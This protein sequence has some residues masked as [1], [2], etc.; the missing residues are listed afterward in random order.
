MEGDGVGTMASILV[1]D[2]NPETLALLV[3]L[4]GSEDYRVLPADSGQLGLS[5]AISQSPD[6]IL[7]DMRMPGMDGLET[8]RRLKAEPLTRQIPVILMS[9]YAEV[10][11]WSAGLRAGAVD[12]VNK[13]FHAEELLA[14]IRTQLELGAASLK[15]EQTVATRTQ[16]LR[17]ANLRLDALWSLVSL[18][19]QEGAEELEDKAIY[20]FVLE[21]IVAMT[22]SRYGFFGLVDESETVMTIHAWSGQAMADCAMVHKPVEYR[23]AEVGL[24][25]EAVR[26][27]K[28]LV[29]NDYSAP[30]I[31]RKGYPG[32]HVQLTRLMV[33]PAFT[34]GRISA[35]AAVANKQGEYDDADLKQLMAFMDGVAMTLAHRKIWAELKASELKFHTV[36]DFTYDLE[37]WRAP[38]GKYVYVSPSCERIT[39][40]SAAEFMAGTGL[41]LEIVLPQDRVI[42]EKHYALEGPADQGEDRHID[43]R[44]I[45]KDGRVR[46]MSHYCTQ[47]VDG[48]GN[49]IGRRASNRDITDRKQTEETIQALLRDKDLLLHEVHHRIKNNMNSVASLLSLQRCKLQDQ[50]AI[51]ALETAQNR[52]RSMGLL[53]DRLYRSNHLQAMAVGNYLGPLVKEIVEAIPCHASI[54]IV[55]D[56]GDFELPAQVLQPLGIVVNEIVTN[57]LKYAFEGRDTGVIQVEACKAGNRVCITLGDDGVGLPSSINFE[58]SSGLGL[59]L[60]KALVE[61]MDA[62][63]R[64]E[65][66]EGTKFIVD[67]EG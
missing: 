14:R 60:I 51:D 48:A 33:V 7:L 19:N 45:T 16:E 53:Y 10:A 25:G 5:A 44:F 38:D 55:D 18:V 59:V 63:V 1:I 66:T 61:Q 2:D 57:S 26:Y 50:G 67:F 11:Q 13:P 40:Y 9:A 27:R 54:S 22:A 64:M 62:T 41:S 3:K 37:T 20:D 6:L 34:R 32:G 24:W 42:I 47:V 17:Q 39:G 56:I 46:W 30:D 15:L 36:A 58:N 12:F 52:L 43:F 65:T 29:V 4:L 21:K 35:V 49:P 28:P 8:C 31:A 23:I